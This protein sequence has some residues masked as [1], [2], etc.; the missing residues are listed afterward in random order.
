MSLADFIILSILALI[1]GYIIYRQ[2]F[3]K[4]KDVCGHCPYKKEGC[5]CGEKK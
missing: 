2:C 3:R 5:D 4:D 1:L